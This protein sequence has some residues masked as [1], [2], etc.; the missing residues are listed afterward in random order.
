MLLKVKTSLDDPAFRDSLVLQDLRHLL[1]PDGNKLGKDNSNTT[2]SHAP[3]TGGV[4]NMEQQ[5]RA[6]LEKLWSVFTNISQR[7]QQLFGTVGPMVKDT[8]GT[9]ERSER[10][11]GGLTVMGASK[12][13]KGNPANVEE[14][15]V[16]LLVNTMRHFFCE[17]RGGVLID[18]LFLL[19]QTAADRELAKLAEGFIWSSWTVHDDEGVMRLMDEATKL[20]NARKL[21]RSNAALDKVLKLDPTHAEAFNRRA[22]NHHFSGSY[23]KAEED[24]QRVLEFEP[25]HFGALNG[26]GLVKMKMKNYE[27]ALQAFRRTIRVNPLFENE[28]MTQNIAVCQAGLK[29]KTL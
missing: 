29:A 4:R 14:A 21:D 18:L 16:Q 9:R 17:V 27:G 24:I 7:E 22:T 11:P 13:V 20:S 26:L 1:D 28:V 10:K 19:L 2:N 23:G 5:T 15:T 3:E 8:G 6:L 12:G 25:R